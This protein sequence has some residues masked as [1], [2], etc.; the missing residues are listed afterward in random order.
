MKTNEPLHDYLALSKGQWDQD[1]AKA[2]IEASIAKFYEWYERNVKTGQFKPGSRLS[3]DIA[4]VTKSGIATD[5]PFGEAKEVIGGYWIIVARSLREAAEIA[6][7]NP[8]IQH[9]IRFEVRPLEAERA[10]AYNVTNEMSAERVH[11]SPAKSKSTRT[12][13][14][15]AQSAGHAAISDYARKQPPKLAAVCDALRAEIDAALPQASSKVWHGAPVWFID[16]YPVVGYSIKAGKA[17]L[18]FWNGQAL[19]EPALKPMGKHFAAE[20]LFAQVSE[21][22]RAACRRW[23]VKAGKNIFKDYASLRKG[24]NAKAPK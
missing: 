20:A 13:S 11:A 7:Q 5:G 6:A 21:L 18:L 10:S 14:S 19:G 9:G 17:A 8:C 12:S 2:D 15:T 4:M 1:A 24:G 3:T 16:D 22:D 23:L